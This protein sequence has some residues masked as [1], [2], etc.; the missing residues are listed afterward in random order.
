MLTFVTLLMDSRTSPETLRSQNGTTAWS[1]VYKI[2]EF[3]LDL[4]LQ[5]N[6]H[7]AV[8]MGQILPLGQELQQ[9]SIGLKDAGGKV[10]ENMPIGVAGDF[11]C[12]LA[13]PGTYE[14]EIKLAERT[15]SVPLEV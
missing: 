7:R 12:A 14:L 6:S 5:A 1:R 13:Y 8:L 9:S 15:L 4:N 2:E 11:R 10:F 3:Y